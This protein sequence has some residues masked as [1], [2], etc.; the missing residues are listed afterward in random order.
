[1]IE[2]SLRGFKWQ[3]HQLDPRKLE[4]LG[5]KYN[6]SPIAA[7]IIAARLEDIDKYEEFL[8]PTLRDNLPDPYEMLDM[9]KGAARFVDA[10]INDEH[11]AIYGDY[12]VD[13]ATSSALLARFLMMIGYSNYEIYIPDRILEGYGP[14]KEAFIK[15]KNS[16]TKLI[17]TVDCGTLS[18]DPIEYAANNGM[19][20]IVLDHHISDI[21]L[22]QAIAVINPNRLD[23]S[24]P[25]NNL[26]AVG[27]SFLFII[28]VNR[29]LRQCN[30]YSKR[31]EPDLILLL[32][33]VALGTVCDVM[34]LTGINRL[35]VMQGLKVIKRRTNQGI[36]A[37]MDAA[38]IKNEPDIYHLGF[39]LGPRINAAGR[40]GTCYLG[41]ELLRTLE[42][43]YAYGL[44]LELNRF[45][46]ERKSMEELVVNE[47]MLI[48]EQELLNNP[49]VL[50]VAGNGWHPGV[51]GIVCSQIKEK[52]GLP[53]AVIAIEGE[54][55]KSSLRSVAG[56]DIG[57]AVVSAK[58]E[59]LLIAGGGHAMAA[60]FTI[61]KENIP[62]I[63]EYFDDYVSKNS[64]AKTEHI[65]N[66]D[67]ELP[68][69]RINE[70]IYQ[71]IRI[72]APY[73]NGNNE[74]LV[75]LSNLVLV[76]MEKYNK[77]VVKLK[78]ISPLDNKIEISAT[79]FR[80]ENYFNLDK[81]KKG[82]KYSVIG[83]IALND[84]NGRILYE[85]HVED[86]INHI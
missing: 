7:E 50:V 58:N 77:G 78:F 33:L 23:E 36:A 17:V 15:L 47:A 71:N 6:I 75:R 42:Y 69:I 49:K 30:Y 60:G 82:Y 5:Q 54:Y 51:I 8:S 12:D 9:E 41:S 67:V 83:K 53:T 65:R 18:F 13:G 21:I 38:S 64:N 1:M 31:R 48:A 86:I 80:A 63:K 25:H 74:P 3:K 84:W 79:I 28:A 52:Y 56:I 4:F 85:L 73:G 62:R 29:I 2:L 14:N 22:P 39:V 55:G 11:I 16:C 70:N 45:N 27:V 20:V 37:L 26:A 34:T 43:D 66:Y 44:A 72:A 76:F 32:D 61:K 40:V 19:D 68:A 24:F 35:F 46:S 57:A 10:I 59:Q 81:I